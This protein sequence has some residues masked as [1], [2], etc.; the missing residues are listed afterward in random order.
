[1]K[2][3]PL[4]LILAALLLCIYGCKK[5][6]NGPMSIVGKWSIVK[7]VY[8]TAKD[9]TINGMTTDYYNFGKDG[10]L[11]IEN[12]D[13]SFTGIYSLKTIDSVDITIYTVDGHGMGVITAPAVYTVSN[14]TF[15]TVTLT[16]PPYPSGHETVF[17]KR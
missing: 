9:T 6:N 4:L 14:L 5:S 16:S 8:L 10:T 12:H 2:M 17:L 3:K 15:H 11:A 7:T 1:M 13:G